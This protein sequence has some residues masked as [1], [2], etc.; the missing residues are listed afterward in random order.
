MIGSMPYSPLLH[1]PLTIRTCSVSLVLVPRIRNQFDTIHYCHILKT[2]LNQWF[3]WRLL[4][5]SVN[6]SI[7]SLITRFELWYKNINLD[8]GM[9]K[10]RHFYINKRIP[11]NRESQKQQNISQI[12][13]CNTRSN[14]S[15]GWRTLDKFPL[16]KYVLG[17]NWVK[18]SFQ[19]DILLD[20]I[21][22]IWL[23]H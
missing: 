20:L 9:E 13:L 18:Q 6:F 23:W 14:F 19:A 12:D 17:R 11:V 22:R 16:Y 2:R 8:G 15:Q 1:L 21:F 4:S 10:I 7:V 5:L 3:E